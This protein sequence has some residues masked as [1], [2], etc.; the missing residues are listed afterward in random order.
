MKII[1]TA[2]ALAMACHCYGQQ[3]PIG[4][5]SRETGLLLRDDVTR[6]LIH[7][8][9]GDRAYDYVRQISMWDRAN[10]E[11]NYS[12]AANW[13][14]A[15]AQEFGISDVDIE[16]YP[17]DGKAEYFGFTPALP[18]SVKK[19]ELWAVAPYNFKITSYDDLPMSLAVN[20][21]SIDTTAELIEVRNG[22]DERDYEGIDVKN[23]IV[24]TDQAPNAVARIAVL[25]KGALGVDV[26][27]AVKVSFI[28]I[29][30]GG[31]TSDTRVDDGDVDGTIGLL[32][33]CKPFTNGG[34]LGDINLE[35]LG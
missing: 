25:Q 4:T 27:D 14:K 13:V 6:L 30:D 5:L 3:S 15:K 8:S 16:T 28:G 35:K 2:V 34:N 33:S 7:N 21:A 22:L 19:A 12:E 10:Y 1:L 9:S 17:A 18:W 23:K 32:D 20:S 29:V 26:E 31:K 11:Q 24:L